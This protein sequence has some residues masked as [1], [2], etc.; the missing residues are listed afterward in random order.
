MK[1]KTKAIIATLA[2]FLAALFFIG[3]GVANPH[4]LGAF[5]VTGVISF[6]A[7]LLTV[8]CYQGF[9]EKFEREAKKP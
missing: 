4:L 7:G 6:F 3:F 9:K 5:I 8:A 2:V 1:P